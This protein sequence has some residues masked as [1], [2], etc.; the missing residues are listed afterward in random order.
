MRSLI[1][2]A[3]V[4]IS[5]PAPTAP[6]TVRTG[7][8]WLFTIKDGDLVGVHKVAATAKPAKGEVMVTVRAMFGTA[9]IMTNNSRIPY[10][11]SAELLSGGK[12]TAA[13]ACSLPAGAKPIYEQW[14]QKADA[15][16]IGNFRA[17][18]LE[19]RC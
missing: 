7:E 12:A 10:T 16:R 13:R 17:A 1:A 4:A 11:F 8:S 19:G 15:V 5:S 3:L 2:L 6:L 9:M 18:G 14:E